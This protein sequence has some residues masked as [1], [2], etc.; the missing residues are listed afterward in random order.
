MGDSAL[1]A[2]DLLLHAGGFSA[3]VLDLGSIAPEYA[4]RIPPEQVASLRP[5]TLE[6]WSTCICECADCLD[7]E[8]IKFFSRKC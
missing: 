6:L 1:R 7:P 8:H 2:T 4:L 3:I 5:R